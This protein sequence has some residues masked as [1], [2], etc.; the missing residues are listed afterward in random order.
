VSGRN[1]KAVILG[2]HSR[3]VPDSGT[4][5]GIYVHPGQL[6]VS[7]RPAAIT[8]V[9]GSCVS[10]C[11]FDPKTRVGGLNHFL[12]PLHV[13]REKS[14][15]FGSVAVPML[16]EELRKLG[17]DR[18]SL[19]AKVFGGGSII[20]AFRR[21]GQ[22]GEE[23]VTLALQLLSEAGIPVLDK[24]VGGKFGRKLIFHT[25]DGTAWVRSL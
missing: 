16:I 19:Q 24:D 14:P 10:V 22:L 18:A 23:N 6:V 2:A 4:R 7:A 9:L 21:S 17:A 11:L 12:L 5:T 1:A 8:T 15:R 13:E 20:A 25:D 3:S